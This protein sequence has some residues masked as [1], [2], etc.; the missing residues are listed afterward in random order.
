[1]KLPDADTVDAAFYEGKIASARFFVRD[2]LPKVA[3][4]TA[5]AQA[6]DAWLMRLADEAF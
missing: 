2:A 5:A 1:V 3:I 4:R 6:E